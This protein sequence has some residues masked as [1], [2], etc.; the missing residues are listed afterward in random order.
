MPSCAERGFEANLVGDE[1][2]YGPRLRGNEQAFE[3]VV[4][5]IIACGLE[6][7]REVAIAVDV[8]STHFYDPDRGIYQLRA[9]GDQP[10]DS[11]GMIDLLA[12]WVK[13]YPIISIEDGLAEDDWAG[14]AA[15]DSAIGHSQSN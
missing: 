14:W 10:L 8:A 1:G 4:D 9:N 6:P 2:G 13:R 12:D 3:V 11:Q 7:G 5:A 15:L